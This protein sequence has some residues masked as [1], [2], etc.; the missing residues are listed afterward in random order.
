MNFTKDELNKLFEENGHYLEDYALSKAYLSLY[1]LLNKKSV[2][3]EVYSLCLDG[4][5]GAGKT[6]FVE[7]Y[8]KIAAKLLGEEVKFINFQLDAETGKDALY[9][10]ID[11]VATFENDTSKIRIQGTILKAINLVNNG[12]HVILKLDEYDKARDSVDTFF[13][14]FLQEGRINTIQHGDIEIEK[15]KIGNLQ[16]FLCKNDLRA[17]L[18][19]PM[20]RRNRIFRLDYMTPERLHKILTEFTKKNKC[21]EGLL[22]LVTLIYQNIYENREMY[23]KLPSCSECQQSIMD[24]YLLLQGGGFTR[25]DVY[26]NII[27]NMLKINDDIKTFEANLEKSPNENLKKLITEMKNDTGEDKNKLYLNELIAKNIFDKEN[28]KLA[29]KILEMENLITQYR[30]K[31]SEME[32]QRKQVI[33]AEIEKIKL[34]TG[35]LV[36]VSTYP[37]VVKNFSDESLRIKRGYDIFKLSKDEWTDIAEITIPGLSHDY[38]I[39]KL[40]ENADELDITIYENGI[41][42][43]KEQDTN[44]IVIHD[45]DNNGNLRYRIMSSISVIPSTYI[46]DIK[47]FISFG[48]QTFSSQ[49]KTAGQL[50]DRA[51]NLPT[52]SYSFNAL[53]YNDE[54]LC[55]KS[56]DK[57]IDFE[58]AEPNIYSLVFSGDSKVDVLE[59]LNN[60]SCNNISE[61]IA[62]SK[63]IMNEK[64]KVLKDE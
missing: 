56:K 24:A 42:L 13:N 4:P 3:Q 23:T 43:K 10:D 34:Q 2:G 12:Y 37:N 17:E 18:S 32:E 35:E 59:N 51:M 48:N 57:K 62:S 5:S 21:D 63:K 58:E 40:I 38:F 26:T 8:T 44:L 46:S 47:N 27:E 20:V 50:L 54:Q 36:A 33:E 29:E 6:S 45:L 49:N 28:D 22:N 7:T 41:V 16:V 60:I 31:F 11:V 1:Y 52:Y 53:V 61:A 64:K 9:E 14:N 25:N 19:E 55:L 15:D 39:S 30:E